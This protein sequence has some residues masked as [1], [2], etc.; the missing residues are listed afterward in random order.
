LALGPLPPSHHTQLLHILKEELF[1]LETDRLQDRIS[2]PDYTAQKS[3]L[4]L[5]LRRALS[6]TSNP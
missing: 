5:I 3:A 1:A 2:E 4:E 6:R